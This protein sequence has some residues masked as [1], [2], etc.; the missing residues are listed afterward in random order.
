MLAIIIIG[1]YVF[2][3]PLWIIS[4]AKTLF[5]LSWG[6]HYWSV[7]GLWLIISVLLPCRIKIR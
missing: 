3:T 1:L 4:V 7:V 2:A 5:G 6:G